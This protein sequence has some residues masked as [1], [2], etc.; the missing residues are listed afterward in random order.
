MA[1]VRFGLAIRIT[2]TLEANRVEIEYKGF[3]LVQL[4]EMALEKPEDFGWWGKD[5]MFDTWGWAGID[6]SL[7]SDVLQECNFNVITDDLIS[8]FPEDFE[9]VGLKHWAVG[10]VDRLTVRILKN[11]G[12]IV[13]DNIT[14]AFKECIDWLINLDDY[15]VADEAK[16]DDHCFQYVFDM[17]VNDIPEEVY[18]KESKEATAYL[19]IN[20]LL[21]YDSDVY[22]DITGLALDNMSISEDVIR[23]AAYD[24]DLCWIEHR[25]FWDE[26]TYEQGLP[27]IVW[28]VNFGVN[29]PNLRKLEGQLSLFDTDGGESNG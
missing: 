9:I 16:F 27:P 1:L 13:D 29:E 21:S 4:A 19:I 12:E 3:N 7:A 17:L 10:H 24:L 22:I 20:E 11:S 5:E 25:D 15:P 6:K 14:E 8:R 23:Y 18:I 28:G 2:L 26:W